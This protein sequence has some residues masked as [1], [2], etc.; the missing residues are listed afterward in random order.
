MTPIDTTAVALTIAEHLLSAAARAVEVVNR[1]R[2]EGRP[3]S[4]AELAELASQD[5]A[6]R[7]AL[8]AQIAR[9]RGGG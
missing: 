1:A 3:V 7:A 2:A 5:D 4:E 6:A 9:Q 8:D